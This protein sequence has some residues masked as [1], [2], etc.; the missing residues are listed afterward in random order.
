MIDLSEC[1]VRVTTHAADRWA[2]LYSDGQEGLALCAQYGPQVAPGIVQALTGRYK[3]DE[4]STYIATPDRRG[5]IV[6]VKT[7]QQLVIV[8]VL[9]LGIP[10]IAFMEEHFAPTVAHV[11]PLPPPTRK[12]GNTTSA[13]L[14]RK[15]AA[16]LVIVSREA[17]RGCPYAAL[18]LRHMGGL[19]AEL[20][21][22]TSESEV[23]P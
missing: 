11:D 18:L 13:A 5:I 12:I 14:V 4:A 2:E 15:I 6:A 9:R 16:S 7:G 10:Q 21:A 8:T 1:S 19:C 3:A 22:L 17:D 20:E 23:N